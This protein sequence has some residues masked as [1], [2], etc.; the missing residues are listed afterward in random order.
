SSFF[1]PDIPIGYVDSVSV[2]D[3]SSTA[4]SIRLKLATNFYNLEYVYVIENLLNDEQA[5]LEDSTRKNK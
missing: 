3:K 5:N 2:E 1:P 4:F